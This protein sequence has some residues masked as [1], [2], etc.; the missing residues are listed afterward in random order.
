MDALTV[1]TRK[2]KRKEEEKS[3]D[4]CPIEGC[5]KVCPHSHS[6]V[7]FETAKAARLSSC[8][9]C[10]LS[11]PLSL[12][13]RIAP[14]YVALFSPVLCVRVRVRVR[15]LTWEYIYTPCTILNIIGNGSMFDV[16]S[17]CMRSHNRTRVNAFHASIVEARSSSQRRMAPRVRLCRTAPMAW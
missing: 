7:E 11:L 15:V 5:T 16:Q 12:L 10:S 13:L 9:P 14:L 3:T 2:R 17:H 1:K 6:S 8:P 4:A